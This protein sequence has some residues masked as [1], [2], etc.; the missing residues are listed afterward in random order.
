VAVALAA[1][2]LVGAVLLELGSALV[3]RSANPAYVA[4]MLAPLR[5]LGVLVVAWLVLDRVAELC[6]LLASRA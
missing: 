5:S 2:L 6:V 1:P 4:P 3:A